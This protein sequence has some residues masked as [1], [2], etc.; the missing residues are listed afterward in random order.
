MVELSSDED[1]TVNKGGSSSK[2]KDKKSRDWS[3]AFGLEEDEEKS[4]AEE[5]KRKSKFFIAVL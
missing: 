5:K 4:D 3:K 1:R 2:R